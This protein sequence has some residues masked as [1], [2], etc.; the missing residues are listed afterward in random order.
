MVDEQP[1]PYPLTNLATAGPSSLRSVIAPRP[2]GR[3]GSTILSDSQTNESWGQTRV[4]APTESI[5]RLS[6][7]SSPTLLRTNYGDRR[8]R[9]NPQTVATSVAGSGET[10]AIVE[11]SEY[12]V[13][14]VDGNRNGNIKPK[15]VG[16]FERNGVYKAG[17]DGPQAR[18]HGQ[19]MSDK[20]KRDFSC[21]AVSDNLLAIGASGGT[22]LIFSIGDGEQALGKPIFKLEQ[23]DRSVH[24]VIFN[25]QSTELVVLSSG[26]GTDTE[27]CQFYSVGQFPIVTSPRKMSFGHEAKS[28][29]TADCELSLDL[30]YQGNNEIYPFTLQD[31]KFS[32][33]G[34][35]LI[36]ITTHS[37]GCA[38][39]YLMRKNEHEQWGL[40]G[41]DRIIAHRLDSWD[42]DCLGFTG[43]SLYNTF[44]SFANT[45]LSS[46]C[47]GRQ[48]PTVFRL[49]CRYEGQRLLSDIGT[50]VKPGV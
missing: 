28:D 12:R 32:E 21:A 19:I 44:P 4:I 8:S 16:K 1:E 11:E 47:S 45:K 18:S 24:K 39:V 22:F 46:K 2:E 14:K 27:F 36:A 6:R 30:T 20:K 43:V 29:F 25:Q 38:M 48:Y 3:A 10:L 9:G 26:R 23:P 34:R 35:K 13:Y 37:H 40:W 15:C 7:C 31:A 41:S 42:E 33:D 49:S 50:S 5:A 17:L